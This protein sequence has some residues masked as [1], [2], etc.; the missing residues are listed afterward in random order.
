M[1]NEAAEIIAK[2]LNYFHLVNSKE[3][4][5]LKILSSMNDILEKYGYNFIDG[6]WIL[7][8]KTTPSSS[9]DEEKKLLRARVAN[10]E[11]SL[12]GMWSL[13]ERDIPLKERET[14]NRMMDEHFNLMV[15][16]GASGEPIFER[17]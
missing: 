8:N 17:P 12:H 16:Q 9:A 2:L 7:Q 11:I 10:L 5:P 14:I 1:T 3:K 15:D 13:L 6:M 4:I